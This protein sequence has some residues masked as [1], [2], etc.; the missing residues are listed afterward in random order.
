MKAKEF[1]NK[2]KELK[3]FLRGKEIILCLVTKKGAETLKFKTLK[4]FGDKVLE[5]EKLGAGFAFV[6]FGNKY[7]ERRVVT[8]K[9]LNKWVSGGKWDTV[10]LSAST[11]KYQ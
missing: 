2:V 11:L 5:L 4:S 10:H 7:T 1:K 3:E 6:A 9:E 8:E